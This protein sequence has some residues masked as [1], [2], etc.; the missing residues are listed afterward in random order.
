MIA[1]GQ[2]DKNAYEK[3]LNNK[4]QKLWDNL[5]FTSQKTY[6]EGEFLNVTEKHFGAGGFTGGTGG[7]SGYVLCLGHIVNQEKIEV[8]QYGYTPEFTYTQIDMMISNGFSS[9]FWEN[10][11]IGGWATDNE[12]IR[13]RES[14]LKGPFTAWETIADAT[15]KQKTE[16]IISEFLNNPSTNQIELSDGLAAKLKFIDLY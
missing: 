15:E 10:K 4:R 3:W 6:T 1:I 5:S 14:Y 16:K 8:E 11:S 13:V 7:Y 12:I 9:W 2:E